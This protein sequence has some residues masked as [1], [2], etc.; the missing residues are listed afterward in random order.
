MSYTPYLKHKQLL[1]SNNSHLIKSVNYD[2]FYDMPSFSHLPQTKDAISQVETLYFYD[3]GRINNFEKIL[4]R[5]KNRDKMQ[6]FRTL[7]F[8]RNNKI[9]EKLMSR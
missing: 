1:L 2:I 5:N 6:I 4:D 3:F 7:S 8:D 9:R